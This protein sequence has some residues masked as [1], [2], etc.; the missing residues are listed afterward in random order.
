MLSFLRYVLSRRSETFFF[1]LYATPEKTSGNYATYHV[2]IMILFVYNTT[3]KGFVI[4]TCRY[5]KLSWNT[6][7]LSQSNSRNFSCSSIIGLIQ[8]VRFKH[9]KSEN[10]P[11]EVQA[12]WPAILKDNYTNTS[13]LASIN[14][15]EYHGS[16]TR[17]TFH[18]LTV[19][20]ICCS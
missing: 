18:D 17:A 14:S 7:A 9:L 2:Q 12:T 10:N 19:M 20:N 15:C 16:N 13:N 6:T 11:N 8:P 5:F 4:F 3:P 1:R